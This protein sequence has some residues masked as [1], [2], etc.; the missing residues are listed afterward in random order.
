MERNGLEASK[1]PVLV[2]GATGGVGSFSILLLSS[3][4]YDVVA[5]SGKAAAEEQYLKSLG[6]KEVIERN[7]FEGDSRPLGKETYSGC[8]DCCGGVVLANVLPVAQEKGY[9]K[10][11]SISHWSSKTCLKERNMDLCNTI[12]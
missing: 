3:L 8:L 2:T 9:V 5:V 4:G 11:R 7:L 12:C 10:V 6:A 1:G